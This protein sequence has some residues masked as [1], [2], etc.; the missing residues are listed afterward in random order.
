LHATLWWDN[1]RKYRA[2]TALGTRCAVADFGGKTWGI[3]TGM[4]PVKPGK[5]EWCNMLDAL[6]KQHGNGFVV[7]LT[8]GGKANFGSIMMTGGTN[9][10]FTVE[11]DKNRVAKALITNVTQDFADNFKKAIGVDEVD[12][13]LTKKLRDAVADAFSLGD[14]FFISGGE[15]LTFLVETAK[16]NKATLSV[17]PAP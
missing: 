5:K 4:L 2:T 11:L 12:G 7:D 3:M 6:V 15:L 17:Y 16:G 1:F 14:K 10:V 8:G 9:P 13:L